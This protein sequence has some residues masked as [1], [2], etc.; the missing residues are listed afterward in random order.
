MSRCGNGVTAAECEALFEHN[1]DS[2]SGAKV[3]R[4]ARLERYV[5][6]DTTW[7]YCDEE[8]DCG[9]AT[10]KNT[11]VEDQDDETK[12]LRHIWLVCS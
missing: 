9:E 5:G 4:D 8:V 3:W 12:K 2:V 11:T 1:G 6:D 10:W 7:K